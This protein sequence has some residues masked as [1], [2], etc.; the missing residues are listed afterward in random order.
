MAEET[1]AVDSFLGTGIGGIEKAKGFEEVLL[2]GRGER[3]EGGGA[4]NGGED[5]RFV[6]TKAHTMRRAMFFKRSNEGGKVHTWV[7]GVGVIHNRGGRR[8]AIVG[9]IVD[10]RVDR[11]G[12]AKQT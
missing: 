3:V 11:E 4:R 2:V 6:E 10:G 12:G 5:N 8:F 9:V 7:S 1:E